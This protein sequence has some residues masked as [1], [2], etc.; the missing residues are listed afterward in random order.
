MDGAHNVPAGKE[1]SK[2]IQTQIRKPNQPVQWII[3]MISTK[4]HFG[5]LSLLFQHSL[6]LKFE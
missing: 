1:L 2:Y 3:G 6:P 4:D 5:F